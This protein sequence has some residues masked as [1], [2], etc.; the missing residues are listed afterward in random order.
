VHLDN[1][2]ASVASPFI[3]DGRFQW[4]VESEQRTARYEIERAQSGGW[5]VIAADSSGP[6]RHQVPLHSS[7][8]APHRLIEV[9]T[10][11]RRIV[12][13]STAAVERKPLHEAVAAVERNPQHRAAA[14]ADSLRELLRRRR[15][16]RPPESPRSNEHQ[17]PDAHRDLLIITVDDFLPAVQEHLEEYWEGNGSRSVDVL[18][19][20]Q[21]TQT[22]ADSRR[23]LVR[24]LIVLYSMSHTTKNFLLVGDANDWQ[25]FD[26]PKTPQ[27]WVGEWEE[28]RQDLLA[29]GYPA[30]GQP[31]LNMI[32]TF[33]IADPAPR[34]ANMAYVAPYFLSDQ[35]YVE[36]LD[37]TITRWPVSS[38]QELLALALKVQEHDSSVAGPGSPSSICYVGDLDF[39]DAG[40]GNLAWQFAQN[41]MTVLSPHSLVHDFYRSHWTI[42]AWLIGEAALLWNSAPD[43]RFVALMGSLST[44]YRPADILN[45]EEMSFPFDVQSLLTSSETPF[46]LGSSCGAADFARTERLAAQP[47]EPRPICEDFL[48]APGKGAIA[49][50]GPTCGTWQSGN[51][52]LAL[53]L[54]A[55]LFENPERAMA[56]SWSE[57]LRRVSAEYPPTHPVHRTAASYVYL[58]DPCTAFQPP[59]PVNAGVPRK[60]E[61]SFSLGRCA[62]NPF[63]AATRIPFTVGERG[64]IDIS[65]FD[66]SGRKVRTLVDAIFEAGAHEVQWSGEDDRHERAAPGIYF[67]RARSGGREL[68]RKMVKSN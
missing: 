7:S 37:A 44:R 33:A 13:G 50:V 68:T 49:W 66:I 54:I 4:H 24:S 8:E 17:L 2:A 18:S 41:A 14:P 36:N 12:H 27:Y 32:P 35:P 16:S 61:L 6:G 42:P 65:I 34:G 48:F 9:E 56:L 63:G 53:A 39:D 26:G 38:E 47:L 43:L 25:E 58:G 10:S 57:A 64:A 19:L 46:V 59:G 30:G 55:E 20:G 31:E 15:D 52:A 62:P 51:E 5:T 11:G 1:P 21:R 3:Q 23:E 45:K 29:A 28:I 60:G 22:D 67:Y 40:D